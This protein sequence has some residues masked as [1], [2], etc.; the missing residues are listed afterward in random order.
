MLKF[1]NIGMA[2]AMDV[3]DHS[4]IHPRDKQT[5]GYRLAKEAGRVVYG[6]LEMSQ[7]PMFESMRV[8]GNKIRVAFKNVGKGLATKDGKSPGAFAIAGADKTFVWADAVIDGDTVVVSSPRVK[9]P[10][11]VRYAYV[12]FRGDVN[13]YNQDGFPAVPFRSDKPDYP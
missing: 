12:S 7:G 2:V 10:R 9:V 3:G 11:H 1:P 5:L 13:L 4:D 8:E 6:S